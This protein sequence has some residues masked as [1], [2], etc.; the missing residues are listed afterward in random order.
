MGNE[1]HCEGTMERRL[2]PLRPD[3]KDQYFTEKVEDTTER[4]EN[5]FIS[6]SRNINII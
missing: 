5:A 1:H 3:R 2:S 6:Y 4:G